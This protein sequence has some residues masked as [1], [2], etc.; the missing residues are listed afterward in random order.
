M[1]FVHK[2]IVYTHV[3]KAKLAVGAAVKPFLQLGVQVLS[4][5]FKRFYLSL[6]ELALVS[7]AIKVFNHGIELC[8]LLIHYIAFCLLGVRYLAILLMTHDDTVIIIERDI[9]E[10]FLAVLGTEV[11]F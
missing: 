6:G 11:L 1:A 8:Q 10:E 7:C 9:G 3:L 4:A 5:L 2:Q